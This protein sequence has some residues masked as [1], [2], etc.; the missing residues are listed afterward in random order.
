MSKKTPVHQAQ[1]SLVILAA[2]MGSRYGGVKQ[3]EHFTPEGETLIDFS[4]YAALKAG[5][6]KFVFVIR[7]SFEYEFKALF[8][9]KLKGKAEVFYVC[10]EPEYIPKAYQNPQRK[11]PWG[12]G[13]ALLMTKPII[14]EN[15]AVINADDFYGDEAF[16]VMAESLSLKDKS[17]HDYA[18]VAYSLKNTLSKHGSVSRGECMVNDEGYLE[19]VIERTQIEWKDEKLLRKGDAEHQR[20]SINPELYVSMNFWGFT[21]QCFDFAESL[22][23]EFLKQHSGSIKAEFYLPY[24]VNSL[25]E[26]HSAKV[27]MLTTEASWFGV[28]YKEDKPGVVEAFKQLKEKGMYPKSLW[29]HV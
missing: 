27:E 15:F 19:N 23:L 2:G 11:K 4:L 29:N 6:N 12:T 18:M 21:P 8:D 3:M 24:I 14:Q 17:Q 22:F 28:T 7:K 20:V 10:Q 16:M 13:H 26:S 9:A 25:I 1:L 5:F